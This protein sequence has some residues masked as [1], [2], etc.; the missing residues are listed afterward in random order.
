MIKLER[1]AD[2]RSSSCKK[3]GAPLIPSLVLPRRNSRDVYYV[4]SDSCCEPT[5]DC[6]PAGHGR[7]GWPS[8]CQYVFGGQSSQVLSPTRGCSFPCGH[9]IQPF[10]SKGAKK[11]GLQC[12]HTAPSSD[13]IP[14]GHRRH[15]PL[16]P[17]ESKFARHLLHLEAP[18]IPCVSD[19]GQHDLHRAWPFESVY[20]FVSQ[21]VHPVDAAASLKYPGGQA[22]QSSPLSEKCP[23]GHGMQWPPV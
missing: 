9:G 14:F 18:L 2:C 15:E 3:E 22:L 8:L 5:G 11:L 13:P 23:I 12:A 16:I 1:T 17:S 19:P 21:M 7:Q 6:F 20:V 4:H 10:P